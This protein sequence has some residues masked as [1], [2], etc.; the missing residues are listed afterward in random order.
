MNRFFLILLALCISVAASFGQTSQQEF[1]AGVPD[2]LKYV[3]PQFAPGQVVY[4]DGTYSAGKFNISTIDQSIRFI[5]R[6]GSEKA[7]VDGSNVDR[8]TIGGV[9]FLKNLDF[10]VGIDRAVGP[11]YLCVCRKMKFDESKAGAFGQKSETTNIKEINTVTANGILYKLGQDAAYEI[12][13][14]PYLLKGKNVYPITRSTL[15]RA[16]P[17]KKEFIKTYLKEHS[18]NLS[19]YS[20]VS[21]LFS[22]LESR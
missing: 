8:V 14:I 6:D 16:F 3:L 9:L 10:F 19:G 21:K 22:A 15:F 12:V 2:S 13:E 17:D 5:D 1:E 4:K 20:D 11:V 18:V 7:L